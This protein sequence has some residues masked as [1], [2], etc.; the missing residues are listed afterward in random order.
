MSKLSSKEKYAIDNETNMLFFLTPMEN[1]IFYNLIQASELKYDRNKMI[2]LVGAGISMD[3]PSCI[4]PAYPVVTT[5][6]NWIAGD[7]RE[8]DQLIIE[9]CVPHKKL[10]PF[11]FFVLSNAIEI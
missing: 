5:F 2:F 7:D 6:A 3:F 1:L 10:N 8:L 11:N 4:P 9:R